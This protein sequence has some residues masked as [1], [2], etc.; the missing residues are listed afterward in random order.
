MCY[1]PPYVELRGGGLLVGGVLVGM[2]LDGQL[3]V[4]LLHVHLAAILRQ[5]QHLVVAPPVVR[6][7]PRSRRAPLLLFL[8]LLLLVWR[9]RRRQHE[10]REEEHGEREAPP[11]GGA[12][13]GGRV[14]HLCTVLTVLGT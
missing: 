10:E 14:R 13:A 9:G 2:P 11:Q 4:R 1:T 8:L 6:V 5:P 7:R 12:A 3:A